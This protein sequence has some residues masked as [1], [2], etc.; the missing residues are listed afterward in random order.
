[1]LFSVLT[2]QR[3]AWTAVILFLKQFEG[4][5]GRNTGASLWF[6]GVAVAKQL[7]PCLA[8]RNKQPEGLHKKLRNKQVKQLKKQVSKQHKEHKKLN[9]LKKLNMEHNKLKQA[10]QLNNQKT[11]QKRH[12]H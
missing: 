9:K 6:C 2:V 11:L 1:M 7:S 5:A 4:V 8:T 10:K 3:V 12:K